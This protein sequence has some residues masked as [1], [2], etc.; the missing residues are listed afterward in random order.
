MENSDLQLLMLLLQCGLFRLATNLLLFLE[1]ELQAQ[2]SL[3]AAY[4]RAETC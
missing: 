3:E 2:L 1:L 4:I